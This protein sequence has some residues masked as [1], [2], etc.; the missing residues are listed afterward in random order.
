MKPSD[1][2]TAAFALQKGYSLVLVKNGILIATKRGKGISPL[3]ELIEESTNLDG[4]YLGDKVF[5]RAAALLAIYAGFTGVYA[6]V[7]SK[8]A[9]AFLQGRHL[10]VAYGRQVD[11]ILNREGTG[12][13]PMEKLTTTINSPRAAITRIKMK[14]LELKQLGLDQG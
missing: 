9:L 2:A 11:T 7:I 4:A 6:R 10:K 14:L 5:G 1:L 13:C 3:L 12:S 8:S